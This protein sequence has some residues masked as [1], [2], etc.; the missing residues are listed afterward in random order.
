PVLHNNPIAPNFCSTVTS[1]RRL[2]RKCHLPSETTRFDAP[3]AFGAYAGSPQGA[4]FAAREPL[5]RRR[6]QARQD[7]KASLVLWVHAPS[8]RRPR[9]HRPPCFR[10][11]AFVA[12]LRRPA[13]SPGSG[14][15]LSGER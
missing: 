10:R 2:A 5:H 3:S 8:A 15:R 12:L 1:C 9:P 14:G 11:P 13:S 6:R 4:V 7:T